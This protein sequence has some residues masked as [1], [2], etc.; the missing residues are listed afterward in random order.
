M[1]RMA[2]VAALV[3]LAGCGT[4][5]NE[6]V[7]FRASMNGL[8]NT[9][10]LYDAKGDTLNVWRTRAMVESAGGEAWWV[11]SE[12]NVQHHISGTFT[13]EGR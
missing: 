8:Q 13:V 2:V 10:V 9:I 12:D 11:D 5:R 7:K 1:R 3:L 6:T 4:V